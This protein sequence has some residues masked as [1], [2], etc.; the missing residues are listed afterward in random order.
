MILL[1]FN[2]QLPVAQLPSVW[3]SAES[4]S[5]RYGIEKNMIYNEKMLSRIV[6]VFLLNNCTHMHNA[7]SWFHRRFGFFI[8]SICE[9]SH[10]FRSLK[11]FQQLDQP[12]ALRIQY[13]NPPQ[14]WAFQC[15]FLTSLLIFTVAPSLRRQLASAR[16][17]QMAEMCM[18]Q[19][20][21]MQAVRLQRQRAFKSSCLLVF[22]LHTAFLLA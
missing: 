21:R 15:T 12:K 8:K 9:R 17:I 14:F 7:Y 5:Q 2:S 1:R 6:F 3:L 22:Q 18:A 4:N 16:W 19:L 11:I 10:I 20:D 13:K